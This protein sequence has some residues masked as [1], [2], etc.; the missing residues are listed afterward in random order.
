MSLLDNTYCQLCEKFITKQK[1]DKH[2][3]SSGLSHK[4]ANGQKPTYF[5][6]RKL[7]SDESTKLSGK[8]SCNQKY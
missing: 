2:V 1:W 8:C 4:E 6:I 7:T 3:Y 5:P